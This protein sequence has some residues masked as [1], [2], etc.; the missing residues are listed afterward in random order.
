ML[1]FFGD[2]IK[3]DQK[4]VNHRGMRGG[5]FLQRRK[6]TIIGRQNEAE[7]HLLKDVKNAPEQ[8]DN[9][10]V[11]KWD[12]GADC[13]LY[14]GCKKRFAISKDIESYMGHIFFSIKKVENYR[15]H[16]L[17][18]YVSERRCFWSVILGIP[19]FIFGCFCVFVYWGGVFEKKLQERRENIQKKLK[20]FESRTLNRINPNLKL[21]ISDGGGYITLI[22]VFNNDDITMHYM[23]TQEKE[24][25]IHLQNT[26]ST[27]KNFFTHINHQ[28]V[29]TDDERQVEDRLLKIKAAKNSQNK[30][31]PLDFHNTAIPDQS[32]YR[33]NDIDNEQLQNEEIELENTSRGIAAFNNHK[34]I[35]KLS[36]VKVANPINKKKTVEVGAIRNNTEEN[37]QN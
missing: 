24:M 8:N 25:P 10:L 12:Q 7:E 30:V 21:N 14:R 36:I 28:R 13:F 16:N 31:K 11:W 26:D 15:I 29:L 32:N 1:S 18:K 35:G 23:K 4:K 9:L 22:K 5:S 34:K 27:N 37:N 17:S 6:T 2:L 19:F 33:L 20:D 3:C